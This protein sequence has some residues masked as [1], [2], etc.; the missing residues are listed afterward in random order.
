[1]IDELM[2]SETVRNLHI[3]DAPSRTLSR[4][5]RYKDSEDFIEE[6]E[7]D[8]MLDEHYENVQFT[9]SSK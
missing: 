2:T 9:K 3:Y 5:V 7:S 8:V 6:E 1:M 4:K